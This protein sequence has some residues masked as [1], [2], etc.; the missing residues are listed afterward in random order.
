MHPIHFPRPARTV[1]L[2]AALSLVMTS[3]A[4]AGETAHP[5]GP[6]ESL[7]YTCRYLG[8]PVGRGQILVGSEAPLGGAKVWPIVAFARTDPLFVLYPIKDKFVT[9]WNPMTGLTEGND[10]L[11]DEQGKRHRERLRF[12][13]EVN[14]AVAT[15]E[16]TDGEVQERVADIAPGSQDVLAALFTM[17]TF[18]LKLGD[19]EEIPIFT[20]QDRVTLR[21]DVERKETLQ[22]AA[23]TFDVVVLKVQA[24]FPGNFNSKRDIRIYVSD[25]ERHIPVRVDAEFAIG[26]LVVDLV[27]YQKGIPAR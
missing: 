19:H 27:G 1:A 12:Q 10:L 7:D 5:F 24:D 22:V 26:N 21:A 13:R 4:R 14:K 23:G 25:D 18:S 15:R 6:A 20:G 8:I 2:A 16:R 11:A 17:R 9:W 3:A